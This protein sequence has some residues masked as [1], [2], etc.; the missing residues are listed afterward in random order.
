MYSFHEVKHFAAP[1]RGGA[2]IRGNRVTV[3]YVV[4]KKS[5]K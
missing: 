5:L 2:I 1:K 4:V 3:V